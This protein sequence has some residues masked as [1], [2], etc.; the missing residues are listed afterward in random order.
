MLYLNHSWWSLCSSSQ[1]ILYHSDYA[2][3]IDFRLKARNMLTKINIL[4]SDEY[5]QRATDEVAR[6]GVPYNIVINM[7]NEQHRSITLKILHG[8]PQ[9]EIYVFGSFVL[10]D[11][12]RD[13]LV[14]KLLN[15]KE[16]L[17]ER[18]IIVIIIS[19]IKLS[20]L[21]AATQGKWY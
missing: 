4:P 8:T 14:D 17:V 5:L 10:W 15:D 18:F 20:I 1:T 16:G 12:W 7:Q 11:S 2:T 6:S 19:A 3:G 21:N 9:G 13:S